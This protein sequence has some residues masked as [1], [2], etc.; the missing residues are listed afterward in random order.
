MPSL[1]LSRLR[2]FTEPS[3]LVSPWLRHAPSTPLP[4]LFTQSSLA[5]FGLGTPP[6]T[7]CEAER[8]SLRLQAL[9][10]PTLVDVPAATSELDNMAMTPLAAQERARSPRVQFATL[11]TGVRVAYRRWPATSHDDDT[12]V[13]L[14]DSHGSS[15]DLVPLAELLA[16]RGYDV[17]AP[18]MRGHGSSERSADGRYD[19]GTLAADLKSFI[20]DL[21]LYVRPISL[22][23]I[24]VGAAVALRVAAACPRLIGA[25]AAVEFA[26]WRVH[27][28]AGPDAASPVASAAAP[29]TGAE[30]GSRGDA[31]ARGEP[32]PE[33]SRAIAAPK[34]IADSAPPSAASDR[35]VPLAASPPS[36]PPPGALSSL[37]S[38][39][40]DARPAWQTTAA[41]SAATLSAPATLYSPL[42]CF[43]PYQAWV[44]PDAYAAAAALAS[45]LA[46]VGPATA[47]AAVRRGPEA[48]L[49]LLRA[50]PRL[51]SEAAEDALAGMRELA[52][53]RAPPRPSLEEILL[54]EELHGAGSGKTGA[55]GGSSG[56]PLAPSTPPP[57]ARP[58]G[59][60]P[61]LRRPRTLPCDSRWLF[62]FDIEEEFRSLGKIRC[63]V[64]FV[65]FDGSEWVPEKVAASA[66]DRVGEDWTLL[67]MMGHEAAARHRDEH[68]HDSHDHHHH[69]NHHRRSHRRNLQRLLGLKRSSHPEE[70]SESSDDEH[71]VESVRPLDTSLAQHVPPPLPGRLGH[72]QTL[73][74]PWRRGPARRP[75]A[76]LLAEAVSTFLEGRAAEQQ[77]ALAE[78]VAQDRRPEV[79]DIRP[80][81]TYSTIEEARRALGPREP[82]SREALEQALREAGSGAGDSDDE[83]ERDGRATAC[84][85]DPPDY[86]G[87]VG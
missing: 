1:L 29:P 44:F 24:G 20:V 25:V 49:G 70:T 41:P 76:Q 35:A 71:S 46:H 40:V 23:G 14:H 72:A 7:P 79:L 37:A 65:R 2:N 80:L 16:Q 87:F 85:R 62:T 81:P 73:S 48:C 53:T 58:P 31:A 78:E 9:L 11:A 18:D 54:L 45:A 17:V 15:L 28:P 30:E 3:R 8:A 60:A 83:P 74:Y 43:H 67:P 47:T 26:P 52:A 21:D 5:L 13:L 84:C 19:L 69:P 10:S 51:P 77:T 36:S 86:F 57:R 82:P 22:V 61:D 42:W 59:S 68:H 33:I 12:V 63:A 55:K 64:E 50:L 34:R 32:K 4:F 39:L 27:D 38:P 66:A 6:E 75:P 56:R